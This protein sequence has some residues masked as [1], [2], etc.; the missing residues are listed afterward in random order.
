MKEKIEYTD[1]Q[2]T[3]EGVLVRPEKA[4]TSPAILIAHDWTGRNEFAE[5]KAEKL[6]QL[7][8][9]GFAID[10][11]GEGKQGKDKEE[12]GRL[13]T[14]MVENRDL[15]LQRIQA[16]L[17]TLKKQPNVDHKRI[18]AIG[19][20]FGGMCVLDLARSG[21]EIAGVVSFHGLLMPP[22]RTAAKIA[23]KVLALH[24]HDDP[25]VTPDHV[26]AFENEMT[27]LQADWQLH[28]YG[29]TMHG[30]TNPLANDPGFGTVYSKAA[31]RR[32]WQAMK[33]FFEEIFE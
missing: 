10:M 18:A 29:N 6:A 4:A 2:T 31:D 27:R 3:F 23:A 20:C 12:K 9:I 32:S 1:G 30:F 22:P 16:A 21:V 8:Y 15:L 11:F 25:M 5:Q 17:Q 28:V 19:F 7:G 13:I 14:P 24:G 33:D 26:L